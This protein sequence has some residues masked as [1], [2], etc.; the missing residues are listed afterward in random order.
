M[1]WAVRARIVSGW[2]RVALVVAAVALVAVRPGPD[3]A[4]L[5]SLIA[6]LVG[7]TGKDCPASWAAVLAR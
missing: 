2:D 6:Y 4:V 5:V 7:L 3:R 1:R